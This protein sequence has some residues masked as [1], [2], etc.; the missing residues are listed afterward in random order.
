MIYRDKGLEKSKIS[1]EKL[2]IHKRKKNLD[3]NNLNNF[4]PIN[5]INYIS[6]YFKSQLINNSMMFHKATLE[7]GG[8]QL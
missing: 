4:F 7:V 1:C 6:I 2:L 8:E 5:N 3:E